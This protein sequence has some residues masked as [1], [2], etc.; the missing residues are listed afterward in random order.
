[1]EAN[2]AVHTYETMISRIEA[3]RTAYLY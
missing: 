3:I 2:T 1:M